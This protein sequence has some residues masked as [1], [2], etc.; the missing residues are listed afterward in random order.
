MHVYE[1]GDCDLCLLR[2]TGGCAS[3]EILSCGDSRRR[4]LIRIAGYDPPREG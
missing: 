3:V 1:V 4:R 2:C